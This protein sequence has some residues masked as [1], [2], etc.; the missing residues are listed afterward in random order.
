MLK[1]SIYRLTLHNCSGL[2]I[3]LSQ[4]RFCRH[5]FMMD[6]VGF[7]VENEPVP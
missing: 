5:L 2:R 4:E 6:P 3:K 7:C 1:H